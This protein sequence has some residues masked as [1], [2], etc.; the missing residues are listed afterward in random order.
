LADNLLQEFGP[1]LMWSKFPKFAPE[2]LLTKYFR[3]GQ[4]FGMDLVLAL[5]HRKYQI[6]SNLKQMTSFGMKCEIWY[7]SVVPAQVS[8]LPK[9]HNNL[10]QTV[11]PVAFVRRK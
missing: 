1:E 3:A 6:T 5:W 9:F 8:P 4:T 2:I 11:E 10:Y 7:F